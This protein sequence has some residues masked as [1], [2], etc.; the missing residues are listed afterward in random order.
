MLCYTWSMAKKR[1]PP[2]KLAANPSA[3]LP[4]AVART[5]AA[6]LQTDVDVVLELIR[7][8]QK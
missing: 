8:Y 5:T 7:L 6:P 3:R 2:K 1:N 4:K